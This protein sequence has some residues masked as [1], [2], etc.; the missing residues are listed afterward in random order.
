MNLK[1]RLNIIIT[2]LLV[3]VML[4]GALVM[5][6][7]ARDDVRAEVESSTNLV[8]HL[9]D[10]EVILYDAGRNAENEAGRNES[11]MFRLQGLN[12]LR[13]LR[14]E[15]FD[16]QG[17]LRDSNQPF[18]AG[19]E[20]PP[21]A[22]FAR[23]VE[24]FTPAMQATRR[25]VTVDGKVV[26]ELVVTPDP[27]YE[28]TEVWDDILGLLGLV[29]VFFVVVN[30]MVYWAVGRALR[31]VG[32]VLG[33]LGQLEQGRLDARLPDFALPELAHISARF[34]RMAQKLQD[35]THSNHRLT[36]QVI[37]LQEDERKS[38]ARDLHDEIGQ[39]LTAIHIDASTILNA[40]HIDAA[41]ESAVAIDSVSRRM[42]EIVRDMLQRLRPAEID[43]IG[44]EA[45][46]RDL[47]HTWAQRTSGVGIRIEIAGDLGE[48]DDTVAIAAYR[49][50]QECLT[51]I[52]RHANAS[53]T[54]IEVRRAAGM[55]TVSVADNGRGFDVGA[56]TGGFGLAGMRERIDG[57]GGTL[58]IE[59]SPGAGTQV[60]AHLPLTMGGCR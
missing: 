13:H 38:L 35:S 58:H 43:E 20:P 33:A 34:N 37:R 52:A 9:L 41:K 10:T 11:L 5:I 23:M 45:A 14:I 17:R 12:G 24:L 1:L 47:A 29:A 30:T 16:A 2:A 51:N 56:A 55:L 6:R 40:R 32:Q 31:P 19:S 53:S 36:Q 54:G 3:F 21:P 15:F 39:H 60:L 44:L 25:P 27:S 57:L 22:W 48:L 59:S 50:V 28:I 46:L 7:N 26:G 18:F 4:A 42:M 8:L 49:I